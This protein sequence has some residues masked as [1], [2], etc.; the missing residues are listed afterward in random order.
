MAQSCMFA[1]MKLLEDYNI[2]S[3]LYLVLQVHVLVYL[4]IA[5]TYTVHCI[6][7][8]RA[9]LDLNVDINSSATFYGML[10]H[11]S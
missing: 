11:E 4:T 2:L 5:C 1:V 8:C 9:T 7:I 3:K 6:C 10:L